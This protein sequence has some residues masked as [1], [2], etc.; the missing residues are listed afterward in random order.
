MLNTKRKSPETTT[1]EDTDSNKSPKIEETNQ[2]INIDAIEDSS[3]STRMEKVFANLRLR[4]IIKENHGSPIKQLSFL[5]NHKYLAAIEGQ[6]LDN[7]FDQ[8]GSVQR[9]STDT[10]NVLATVGGSEVIYTCIYTPKYFFHLT[11]C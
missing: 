3:P 11:V 6:D 7:F 2:D 9:D 1:F 8:N 10:F 5:Y 4:R